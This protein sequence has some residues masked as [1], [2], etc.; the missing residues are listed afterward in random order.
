MME[1]RQ[2]CHP[3][4]VRRFST[5]ELRRHFLIE[6]I[7][8]PGEV[9]LT[10]SHIDR[11][12]VGG[13]MPSKERLALPTPNAVGT[14]AFMKR[15]EL[16]I[17]NTGGVG[18]VVVGGTTHELAHR[19]AMYVS[20]EAGDVAFET[21]NADEPAKFYLVSTPAHAVYETVKIPKEK[22]NSIAL[23]DQTTANKRTIYQYIIPGVCQSCQL[24]MGLTQLEP[25]SMW[26][27][28]PC[29]THDRRSEAYLYFDLNEDHR[30]V[31]LMGEPNET[32]HLIVANE[33]AI[34]SPGWSI[35][36][37]VG[38]SRYA[39]IWAMGGDNQDYTDMDMV[40]MSELR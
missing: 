40:A 19:D 26:N 2:V 1:I 20:K 29:H 11:L 10:Y 35:H 5:E 21:V 18:R 22:A 38:T 12:V 17:I 15:R 27:T 39:F 33:Q 36:S 30:V 28:M 16:G 7:F 8:S 31:H 3:E 4:A 23:G 14:D 24:V 13:A 25:G 32:R 34:L 37:G 6:R 9:V